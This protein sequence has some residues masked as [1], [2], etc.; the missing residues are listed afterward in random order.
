MEKKLDKLEEKVDKLDSRLDSIERVLDRNTQSL[1]I[2]MK[3]T[4]TLEQYV[5][6]ELKPIKAHVAVVSLGFKGIAWACGIVAGIITF[7]YMIRDL[8]LIHWPR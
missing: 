6:T 3:R 7:M 5:S 4:D 2:H 1:E 8:G